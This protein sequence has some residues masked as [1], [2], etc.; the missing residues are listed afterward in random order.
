VADANAIVIVQG[1]ARGDGLIIEIS[2]VT[3]AAVFK[4][5]LAL[6][7]DDPGMLAADGEVVCRENDV[8][9]GIAT[10][11]NLIL[12]QGNVLFGVHSLPAQ[13]ICNVATPS[14]GPLSRLL[15]ME[16]KVV[17]MGRFSQF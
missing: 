9:T 2:S 16:H 5:K 6:R 8:A 14:A 12:L 7:T 15:L 4:E 13:Q 1:D 10:E 3:T 11:N 17:S